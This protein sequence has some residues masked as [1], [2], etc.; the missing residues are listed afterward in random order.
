VLPKPY[1]FDEISTLMCD[2]EKLSLQVLES[3]EFNVNDECHLCQRDG[4]MVICEH[5][6]KTYH[7]TCV[8]FFE[9]SGD[10]FCKMCKLEQSQRYD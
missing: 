2:A 6:P 3:V 9:E 10:Y 1:S 7:K 8:N 4:A 5:C